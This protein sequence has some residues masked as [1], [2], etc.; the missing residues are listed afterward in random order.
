MQELERNHSLRADIKRQAEN[1]LPVYAECGGLIYLAREIRWKD[2][3]ASMVGF[4]PGVVTM[5]ER[6]Q[7]R[8]LV[9]LAET[10]QGLWQ[11]QDKTGP[12]GR[13]GL[14]RQKVEAGLTDKISQG[15][16]DDRQPCRRSIL[17][18]EF[19]YASLEGLPKN[20]RFAYKVLRG[21]GIDGDHDGI[22]MNNVQAGFCHQRTT[23][24][25]DWAFRFV[26]FVRHIARKG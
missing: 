10:G 14:E 25:N 23:S 11:C 7:G 22:V 2:R 12:G 19:H 9:K 24:K 1:G 6:P 18:H 21:H 5:H 17:A 8:G 3:R 13:Q 16:P 4:L 26:E 15:K 20:T